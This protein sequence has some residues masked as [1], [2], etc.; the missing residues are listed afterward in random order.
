MFLLHQ[1]CEAYMP[2]DDIKSF[3]ADSMK[4]YG[5]VIILCALALICYIQSISVSG[6]SDDFGYIGRGFKV[7]SWESHFE[8][9][10]KQGRFM[11]LLH[12]YFSLA[13]NLFGLSPLLFHLSNLILPTII[14]ILVY[15]LIRAFTQRSEQFCLSG[16]EQQPG[17]LDHL[18]YNET[19]NA[20][21]IDHKSSGDYIPC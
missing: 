20:N 5:Y 17:N 11:S 1:R 14:G 15:Q 8:D 12:V 9:L 21:V 13:A 3:L 7:T 6:I 2:K 10:L 4:R 16:I 18:R 19:T